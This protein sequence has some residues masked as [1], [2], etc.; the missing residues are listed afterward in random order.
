M[1]NTRLQITL[2]AIFLCLSVVHLS[3]AQCVPCA[4]YGQDL[5]ICS[6]DFNDAVVTGQSIL[7]STTVACTCVT[8]SSGLSGMVNCYSCNDATG[9]QL[10]VL[11][12]WIVMCNT[13]AVSGTGNAVACWNSNTS[14]CVPYHGV[15]LPS[16]FASVLASATQSPATTSSSTGPSLALTTGSGSPTSSTVKSTPSTAAPVRQALWVS[17]SVPLYAGAIMGGVICEVAF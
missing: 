5:S 2:A 10:Q 13:V 7:G 12:Q 3:S 11:E 1:G 9:G 15:P 16:V 14:L 6:S 8:G 4:N 17:S